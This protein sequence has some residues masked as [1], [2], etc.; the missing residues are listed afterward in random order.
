MLRVFTSTIHHSLTPNAFLPKRQLPHLQTVIQI[1]ILLKNTA[2]THTTVTMPHASL[3]IQLNCHLHKISTQSVGRSPFQC[4]F[5]SLCLFFDYTMIFHGSYVVWCFWLH[6]VWFSI[7]YLL[8]VFIE[9]MLSIKHIATY[10]SQAHGDSDGCFQNTVE[11]TQATQEIDESIPKSI[12]CQMPG[13]LSLCI[14]HSKIM[15]L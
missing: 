8:N 5:D 10:A 11:E 2:V 9:Y 13:S 4:S 1:I 14:L 7:D 15:Q 3:R 6:Y 12:P